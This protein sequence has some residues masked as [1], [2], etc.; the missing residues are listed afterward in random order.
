[1]A[2][3]KTDKPNKSKPKKPVDGNGI[4]AETREYLASFGMVSECGERPP[5]SDAW[6]AAQAANS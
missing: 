2:K 5:W 4:I 3:N 1:M 6:K